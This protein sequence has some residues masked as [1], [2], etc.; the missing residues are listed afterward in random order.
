[1]KVT[2]N[3]LIALEGD[4]ALKMMD[5]LRHRLKVVDMKLYEQA[6]PG[7]GIMLIVVHPNEN[8]LAAMQKESL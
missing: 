3:C 2:M 7:N 1:M 4:S 8:K 5:D 6:L